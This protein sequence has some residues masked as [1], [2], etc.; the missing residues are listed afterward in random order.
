MKHIKYLF[1]FVAIVLIAASCGS[2]TE[3]DIDPMEAKKKVLPILGNRDVDYRV[4][5]GVEV[6]DTIYHTI[7]KFAYL[8]QDSV[9]TRSK[10]FEGKVLIVDFFFTHCPSIC[11]PMTAQMRRLNLKT[12]DISKHL[13]FL[14][15]SID[16]ERDTPTRLRWYMEEKNIQ[17]KNWSFFTGNEEATHLLARDFFNGAERNEQIDGGFGHTPYFILVDREGFPR[18]LYN[19]TLVDE[20]DKMEKDI[21]KLLKEEYKVK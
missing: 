15:F 1:M 21:R 20:V 7:P 16:P 3:E 5:N 10:E 8:N 17:A 4:E 18:G 2:E 9:M 11:P 12:K 13:E 19:G 6:I 14:S